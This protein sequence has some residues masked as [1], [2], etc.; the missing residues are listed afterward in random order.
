MQSRACV[1]T[2]VQ[3]L[4]YMGRHKGQVEDGPG[5]KRTHFSLVSDI[6]WILSPV[7]TLESCVLEMGMNLDGWRRQLRAVRMSA[8]INMV[9]SSWSSS[10]G[11][12]KAAFVSVCLDYGDCGRRTDGNRFGV[13]V[14]GYEE[15]GS[16]L[17]SSHRHAN[18]AR[19][20]HAHAHTQRMLL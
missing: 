13:G 3:R 1:E 5:Q 10:A 12:L 18:N 20:A 14:L 11:G 2:I 19:H 9:L 6:F 16:F 17:G 8:D 7:W 15:V 4:D